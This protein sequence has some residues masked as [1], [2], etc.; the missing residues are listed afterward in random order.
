MGVEMEYESKVLLGHLWQR[1]TKGEDAVDQ[2]R[3]GWQR[4]GEGR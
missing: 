4:V 3:Q 2:L 1:Q